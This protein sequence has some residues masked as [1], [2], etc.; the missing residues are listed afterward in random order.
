MK[1]HEVFDFADLVPGLIFQPGLYNELKYGLS[2]INYVYKETI[3]NYS[4]L[5]YT[6]S[7][8]NKLS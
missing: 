1:F 6:R 8:H 2:F 7:V 4:P 5:A 3:Q